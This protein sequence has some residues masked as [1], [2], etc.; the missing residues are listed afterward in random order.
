MSRPEQCAKVL[1]RIR[2][3]GC[4]TTGTVFVNGTSHAADYERICLSNPNNDFRWEFFYNP[5]NIGALGALNYILQMYPDEPWYG[6]IGDDEF[7]DMTVKPGWDTE[8][9]NAA[10]NWC[11]SHA[12]DLWQSHK[13]IHSYVCI[14]GDL[15]RTV[16]YLA[17]PGCWHWYGFDNMWEALT[18]PL[19]LRRWCADI[20]T[21]HLH[22]L[23][24]GASHDECYAL[25]ES[26]T[27]D[28]EKIFRKWYNT[29]RAWLLDRIRRRLP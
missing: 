13:R 27:E 25:G 8:L 26:K 18:H 15:A 28:D 1:T 12:N 22:Y 21:Q 29:E 3:S 4:T 9:V 24:K 23:N 17:I 20:R 10:G 16:G 6:F 7:L 5:E 2:D 14:G 19:G 11:V